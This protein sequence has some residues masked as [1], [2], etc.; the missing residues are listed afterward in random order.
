[1]QLRNDLRADGSH[2]PRTRLEESRDALKNKIATLRMQFRQEARA[3]FKTE[4]SHC[5]V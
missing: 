3:G 1:M 5:N 2:D 4:H